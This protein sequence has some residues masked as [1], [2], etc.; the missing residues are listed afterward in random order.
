MGK[1]A[2]VAKKQ[3]NEESEPKPTPK[4]TE[5]DQEGILSDDE[6]EE[7]AGGFEEMQ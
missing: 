7:A 4:K 2:A 3:S 5:Q 6:L 1:E